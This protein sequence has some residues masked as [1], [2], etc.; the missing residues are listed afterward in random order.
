MTK[1]Q[2][3][4]LQKQLKDFQQA[5]TEQMEKV[6]AGL[7]TAATSEKVEALNA[8]IT[9]LQ[10]EMEEAKKAY[11]ASAMQ[12]AALEMGGMGGSKKVDK[13]TL[14]L[15]AKQFYARKNGNDN[16]R[17]DDHDLKV[18]SAYCEAFPKWLR[19]GQV[20]LDTPEIRA[21]MQ[22]GSDPSGGYWVPTQKMSEILGKL[23]ETSPMRELAD[24][25]SITGDS[26]EFMTDQELAASGGW[27]GETQARTETATPEL[28]M[29]TLYTREQYAQ[30]KIT[31]KLLDMATVNVEAWLANKILEII[32]LTENTAYVSGNGVN[33]PRGFLDYAASAVL[34]ADKTRAWGVLQ[35]VKTG[36]SAGFPT[37]SGVPGA[38]DANFL[39]D[40][41][42][43]LRAPFRAGAVFVM[44]RLTEA[45]FRK[46]RDA[47]GRYLVTGG[48]EGAFT[49]FQLAGFPI[50]HFEDMPLIGADSYSVAFGNFRQGYQIVDG[51]GLRVLRDN[52]TEKP[53]VKFYT[54]KWTGGDVKRY[55]AIKLLK[56][57]S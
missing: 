20:C 31:Q 32:T 57:A 23:H 51:R 25:M 14:T 22:V 54:T 47:D 17:V 43:A 10:G 15:Q 13:E 1:E 24:V 40:L 39:I 46:L 36:T 37:I 9:K 33:K 4:D 29:Q 8:N 56:F 41:T 42:T 18:Y 53:F 19:E 30:P 3:E 55:D 28:G 45:E 5:H 6:K 34:T 2:Y 27:V 50:R 49:G 11:N 35:Y 52:L 7:S 48:I 12:I 44:N 21:A 16:Q 26:I 38:H